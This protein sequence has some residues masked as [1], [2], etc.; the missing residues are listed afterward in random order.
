MK[1]CFSPGS[2]PLIGL[3]ITSQRVLLD[4]VQCTGDEPSL[5]NCSSSG[6]GEHTCGS[7]AGVRCQGI[8]IIIQVIIRVLL[9][10]RVS[11]IAII[12]YT[13]TS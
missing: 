3:N 5:L 1:F 6:I 11:T 10:R 8:A 13:V 4:N 9:F 12:M 2:Q 7:A